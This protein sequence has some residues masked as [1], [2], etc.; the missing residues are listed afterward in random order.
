MA[1]G[2]DEG[3]M[4]MAFGGL[5]T[6]VPTIV[7]EGRQ[8]ATT[9]IN[10]YLNR[11]ED[12]EDIPTMVNDAA[13]WIAGAWIKDRSVALLDLLEM[14]KVLLE[15]IKDDLNVDNGIRWANIRII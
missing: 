12:F 7:A 4:N 10:G 9:I 6:T 11:S 8:K 5:K 14:A 15:T 3:T 13:D 1:Y 2:T